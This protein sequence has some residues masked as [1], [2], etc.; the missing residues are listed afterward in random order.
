MA[1]AIPFE[2]LSSSCPG[3]FTISEL[4]SLVFVNAACCT[5]PFESAFYADRRIYIAGCNT[6]NIVIF[7]P[8]LL[9][10]LWLLSGFVVSRI[11]SNKMIIVCFATVGSLVAT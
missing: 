2:V 3:Q 11:T 1:L 6:S 8:W 10:N 4:F 5:F 9:A 7:S